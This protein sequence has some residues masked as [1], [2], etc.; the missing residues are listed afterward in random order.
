[1]KTASLSVLCTAVLCVPLILSGCAR[2]PSN[3]SYRSITRNL[4]PELMTSHERPVDVDINLAVTRNLEW[5]MF[6]DDLGRAF[7]TDNPSRLRPAPTIYTSGN[8]R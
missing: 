7:Y 8:P 2:D 6:W 4:T 1:M 5:R 3:V